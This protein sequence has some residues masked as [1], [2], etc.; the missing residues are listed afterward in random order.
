MDLLTITGVLMLIVWGL[1]AFAFEAP[2]FIHL[3]LSLGVF[4][5]IFGAIKRS[6]KAR[7]RK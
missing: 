5:L 2:G 6:E 4:F 3:F 7:S 1:G